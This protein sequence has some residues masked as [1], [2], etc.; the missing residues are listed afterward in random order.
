M[1]VLS[2][3]ILKTVHGL[4]ITVLSQMNELKYEEIK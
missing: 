1:Y 3:L 4:G 2:L